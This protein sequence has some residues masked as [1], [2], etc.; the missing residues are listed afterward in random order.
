MKAFFQSVGIVF[1]ILIFML[2]TLVV[3]Y[4]SYIAVAG[5]VIFGG[6]Y[7]V[8]KVLKTNKAGT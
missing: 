7:L 3:I 2:L 4:L 5:L 1:G 8:Y 6:T